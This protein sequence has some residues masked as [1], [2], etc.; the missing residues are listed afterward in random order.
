M[1]R[2]AALGV[3]LA[4]ALPAGPATARPQ[5]D[6]VLRECEAVPNEL[7]AQAVSGTEIDQYFFGAICAWNLPREQINV[8]FAWYEKN[9]LLRERQELERQGYTAERVVVESTAGFRARKPDNPQSC[10]VVLNYLGTATWWVHRS[11]DPCAAAERLA[12]LMVDRNS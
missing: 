6:K 5:L 9:S 12:A 1:K 7:I 8:T 2:V 3:L 10:G 11:P 4:L